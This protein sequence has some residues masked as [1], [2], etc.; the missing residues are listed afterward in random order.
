[1]VECDRHRHHG[2]GH[3]SALAHDRA[4]LDLSE[5]DDGKLG[6]T[7]QRR[8]EATAPR[9]GVADGES[10]AL[11]VRQGRLTRAGRGGHALDL[12]GQ[13]VERELVGLLDHGTINPSPVAV[14]TPTLT[15]SCITISPRS[16]SS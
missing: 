13:I 14:A 2:A 16:S 8:S 1:M 15:S 12:E 10:S 9:A 3:H 11:E 5:A 7:D 4:V 6:R